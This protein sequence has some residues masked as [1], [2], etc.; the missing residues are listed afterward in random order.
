MFFSIIC[1]TSSRLGRIRVA[2]FFWSLSI[3]W[4]SLIA[5]NL[6][7]CNKRIKFKIKVMFF[8]CIT[9][10]GPHIF[11]LFLVVVMLHAQLQFLQKCFL[12]ILA[13]SKL[14][15]LAPILELN[16]ILAVPGFLWPEEDAA[17]PVLVV[18]LEP[19][20]VLVLPF[21]FV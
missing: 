16:Y 17:G 9:Y 14:D 20:V 4:S 11:G 10:L 21:I 6:S 3:C 7:V 18:V 13:Y 8:S 19:V 15:K 12:R 1:M 2:T 5:F